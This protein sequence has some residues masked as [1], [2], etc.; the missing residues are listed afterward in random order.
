MIE[1][2]DGRM[3]ELI[4]TP[5]LA[6]TEDLETTRHRYANLYNHHFPQMAV[7]PQS[8]VQNLGDLQSFNPTSLEKDLTTYGGRQVYTNLDNGQILNL[9]GNSTP[10]P[11]I[12]Q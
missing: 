10:R 5:Q 11:P 2:F 12:P 6:S 1:R 7:N 3:A 4:Q 8:P 9:W